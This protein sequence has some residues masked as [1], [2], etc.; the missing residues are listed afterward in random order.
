MSL[1]AKIQF[2]AQKYVKHRPEAASR[3]CSVKKLSLEVSQNSQEKSVSVAA[4]DRP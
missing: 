1:C 3:R 4:S 2:F